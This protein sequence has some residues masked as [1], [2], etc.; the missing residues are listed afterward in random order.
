MYAR[1][2]PARERCRVP[3]IVSGM[4]QEILEI[5]LIL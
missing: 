1:S 3:E 5:L 2:A 4:R